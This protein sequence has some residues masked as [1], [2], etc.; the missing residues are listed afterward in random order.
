MIRLLF[1]AVVA[2]FFSGFQPCFGQFW[3]DFEVEPHLYRGRELKDPV[4]QFLKKVRSG[5]IVVD[6]GNGK[7]LVERL[8]REFNI[9][10][11]SQIIVFTKTSLQRDMVNAGNPRALYF[12]EDVYLGWMPG[13]RVEIASIDPHLG[14]I[15]YFQRPLNRP[16]ISFFRRSRNCLGCHAVRFAA[17]RESAT[18]SLM[19][20][21]GEVGWSREP[22]INWSITWQMDLRLAVPVD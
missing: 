12:N 4:S 7:P 14:P 9:P 3:N 16:M 11:S 15:F 5:E 6:E 17:S 21:V 2:I 10:V 18:M 13:G 22:V 19:R 1:F 20:S 8:L